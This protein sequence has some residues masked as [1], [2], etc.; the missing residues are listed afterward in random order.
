MNKELE[1]RTEEW[2]GLERATLKQRAKAE[3]Y[4]DSYVM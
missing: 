4:Y 3:E 2:M 1:K